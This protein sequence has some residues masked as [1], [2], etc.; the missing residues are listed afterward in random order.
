[1]APLAAQLQHVP[2]L[3][4]LDV[5]MHTCDPTELSAIARDVRAASKLTVLRFAVST[6]HMIGLEYARAANAMAETLRALTALRSLSLVTG[7]NVGHGLAFH[8]GWLQ[9]SCLP[10]PTLGLSG[11][12]ELSM[13]H[14]SDITYIVGMA[15]ALCG[16]TSIELNSWHPQ[17][18]ESM[19]TSAATQANCTR[20]RK[21]TLH[22]FELWH[23]SRAHRIADGTLDLSNAAA[24]MYRTGIACFCA[25]LQ[26]MT[27]LSYLSIGACDMGDDAAPMLG[28]ALSMLSRLVHI[29]LRYN[30][31]TD[32]G[33]THVV[34]HTAG[35][36][37]LHTIDLR[38]TAAPVR[39]STAAAE[40]AAPP[41]PLISSGCM[42]ELRRRLPHATWL[43]ARCK[44]WRRPAACCKQV[45]ARC[46]R[47]QPAVVAAVVLQVAT[48][49]KRVVAFALRSAFPCNVATGVL[50]VVS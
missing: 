35:L 33:A 26:C 9:K 47:L 15:P 7:K 36:T 23:Y 50:P 29:A 3:R 46:M 6:G 12:Q 25:E 11:L 42:A 2:A 34:V 48:G 31:I 14:M 19:D 10:L 39:H 16:L 8:L 37:H 13:Q 17:G 1:M 28:R 45:Q 30:L 24:R 44:R 21:L 38:K 18:W 49:V 22:K 41:Q 40:A 20:L 32:A 27:G 43:Q 5:Q 4:S